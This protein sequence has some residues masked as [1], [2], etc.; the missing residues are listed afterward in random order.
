MHVLIERN[1][2]C[3]MF[4]SSQTKLKGEMRHFYEINQNDSLFSPSSLFVKYITCIVNIFY[5][6]TRQKY[7]G[8]MNF[9]EQ[10][11]YNDNW[12]YYEKRQNHEDS[13]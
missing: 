4:L 2:L 6:F 3:P 7:E 10:I 5:P 8:F 13:F 11:Y 9:Y 1:I 12:R